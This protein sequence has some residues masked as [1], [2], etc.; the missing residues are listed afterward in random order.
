MIKKE[1]NLVIEE[2]EYSKDYRDYRKWVLAL[3][4]QTTVN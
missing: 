3:R 1:I 2:W 4:K